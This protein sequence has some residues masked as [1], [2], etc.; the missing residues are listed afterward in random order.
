LDPLSTLDPLLAS[1]PRLS[2]DEFEQL[3]IFVRRG[4][5][6][7]RMQEPKGFCELVPASLPSGMSALTFE[8]C[9]R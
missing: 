9:K 2:N 8:G 5:L 6:D 7:R 4:L 3:V 1:I